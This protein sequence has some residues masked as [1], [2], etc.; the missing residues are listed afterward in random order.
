MAPFRAVPPRP[1]T[2]IKVRVRDDRLQIFSDLGDGFDGW[3]GVFGQ[4]ARGWSDPP[5][6]AIWLTDVGPEA[7]PKPADWIW[8]YPTLNGCGGYVFMHNGDNMTRY[9]DQGPRKEALVANNRRGA[10]KALD[11]RIVALARRAKAGRMFHMRSIRR[12]GGPAF[13]QILHPRRLCGGA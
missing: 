9:P 4:Y 11:R 13:H 8:Q 3:R 5:P 7:D 12:Y 2:N 1:F 6:G 10:Q